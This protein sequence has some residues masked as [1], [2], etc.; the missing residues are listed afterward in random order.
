[1]DALKPFGW[2]GQAVAA[3]VMAA[4]LVGAVAFVS[5]RYSPPPLRDMPV[6]LGEMTFNER[7]NRGSLGQQP[8]TWATSDFL[9]TAAGSYSGTF[10]LQYNGDDVGMPVLVD[11]LF[12]AIK[13]D[14]RLESDV[15]IRPVSPVL[16]VRCTTTSSTGATCQANGWF[17]PPPSHEDL[18]RIA[19]T[20][21]WVRAYRGDASEGTLFQIFAGDAPRYPESPITTG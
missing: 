16:P 1:M 10:H 7:N 21:T 3:A 14:Y 8:G 2:R 18:L 19:V 15:E 4:A 12:I 6:F 11:A 17:V 13:A 20:L 9:I 5:W